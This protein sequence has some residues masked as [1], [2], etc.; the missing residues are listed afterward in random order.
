MHIIPDMRCAQK[1]QVFE[2]MREPTAPSLSLRPPTR[3]HMLT[4]TE[5]V[6]RS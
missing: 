4:A 6:F 2:Q 1:H 5:P 3:A